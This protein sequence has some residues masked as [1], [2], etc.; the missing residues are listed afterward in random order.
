MLLG[1]AFCSAEDKTD[2][3]DADTNA[4]VKKLI[5]ILGRD[6]VSQVGGET[7]LDLKLLRKQ[8]KALETLRQ[9]GSDAK[10]ATPHLIPLTKHEY[11]GIS[12][13]TALGSIGSPKDD[14]VKALVEQVDSNS[15][16][17]RLWAIWSLAKMGKKAK[18]AVPVYW[19]VIKDPNEPDLIRIWAL[20]GVWDSGV[21]PNRYVPQYTALVLNASPDVAAQA[22]LSLL[23]VKNLKSKMSTNTA[24]TALLRDAE[25]FP[26]YDYV[27]ELACRIDP[28]RRVIPGELAELAR[29]RKDKRDTAS[30]ILARWDSSCNGLDEY[31][32]LLTDPNA[33]IRAAAIRPLDKVDFVEDDLK[34]VI[35]D[36]AV[37]DS[38]DRVRKQAQVVLRK[39]APHGPK[40]VSALKKYLRSKKTERRLSAL[41]LLEPDSGVLTSKNRVS[42]LVKA[43][44]DESAKVRAKAAEISSGY[45]DYSKQLLSPLKRLAKDENKAVASKAASAI[46]RLS[47]EET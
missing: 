47:G 26:Y 35:V 21:D 38:T 3:G 40:F 39:L 13:M 37:S 19:S 12:A 36:M 30:L 29:T 27:A 46:K 31:R 22:A 33:E 42:L 1:S 44:S 28:N 23:F 7:V 8:S 2:D 5:A 6:G 10:A 4:K 14:I 18:A 45:P 41:S 20:G 11:H 17:V 34:P 16:D 32:E 25:S 15:P 9:M 43:M 24:V